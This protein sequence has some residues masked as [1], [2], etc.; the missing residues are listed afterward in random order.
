MKSNHLFQTHL[1]FSYLNFGFNLFIYY[2][3]FLKERTLISI[4]PLL[5]NIG[6]KLT[7]QGPNP[8]K[9]AQRI[10]DIFILMN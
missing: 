8:E 1:Q 2:N 6:T 5:I 4:Y 7:Q 9:N 3:Y 10:R